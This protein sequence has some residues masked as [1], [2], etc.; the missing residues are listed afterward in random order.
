MLVQYFVLNVDERR[1][2]FHIY[3]FFLFDMLFPIFFLI[4]FCKCRT[5]WCLNLCIWSEM[6]MSRIFF[7]QNIIVNSFIP[8]NILYT[9]QQSC[10]IYLIAKYIY[11]LR[12]R[13]RSQKK[14]ILAV[15]CNVW[16][17]NNNIH[18]CI[19]TI[20]LISQIYLLFIL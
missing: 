9:Y 8:K 17:K 1:R 14:T 3:V 6:V 2:A 12:W 4:I 19:D 16:S 20:T 18:L 5:F 15:F 13:S 7:C 10:T 11:G